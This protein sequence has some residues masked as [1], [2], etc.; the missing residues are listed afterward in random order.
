MEKDWPLELCQQLS[1]DIMKLREGNLEIRH[2]GLRINELGEFYVERFDVEKT[3]LRARHRFDGNKQMTVEIFYEMGD[4][5]NS[6]VMDRDATVADFLKKVDATSVSGEK[7][8]K[9]LR[10]LYEN[11]VYTIT[12]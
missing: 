12:K 9:K 6:V 7:S 2:K 5:P 3:M 1:A 11:K 4:N 10:E 8:T